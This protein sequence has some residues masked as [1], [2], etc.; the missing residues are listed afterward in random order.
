MRIASSG[1]AAFEV[2]R[3]AGARL[4]PVLMKNSLVAQQTIASDESQRIADSFLNVFPLVGCLVVAGFTAGF[5][6]HQSIGADANVDHCLAQ[7]TELL[8][9]TVGFGLFALR[10]AI[11]GRAGSSTHGVNVAR[12]TLGRYVTLV[13]GGD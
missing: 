7:A 12:G 6:V 11:A 13:I 8:A 3:G 2:L 1:S 4:P 9:F 10:A 5:A